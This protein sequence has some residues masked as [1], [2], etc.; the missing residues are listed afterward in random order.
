MSRSPHHSLLF[1]S[2]NLIFH[3]AMPICGIVVLFKTDVLKNPFLAFDNT[4]RVALSVSLGHYAFKTAE[5]LIFRREVTHHK[6]LLVHHVVAIMTLVTILH[7]E[8]NAV[9]GVIGLFL[10]GYLVF[11]EFGNGDVTTVFGH[12]LSSRPL[13]IAVHIGFIQ[14][15]VTK[16]LIPIFLISSAFSNSSD[17]LL[18]MDYIPLAFFFLG[19]V[20]FTAV[21]M[22][23]FNDTISEILHQWRCPPPYEFVQTPLPLTSVVNHEGLNNLCREHTVRIHCNNLWGLEEP[24]KGKLNIEAVT[25]NE[26]SPSVLGATASTVAL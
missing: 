24:E 10:E 2:T 22:W 6:P 3:L 4:L 26:Y 13:K 7:F 11:A 21:N 25:L 5:V 17:E 12:M 19:L 1:S 9:L 15:L 8:Q 16:A 18:K 14:A 20:F 23:F